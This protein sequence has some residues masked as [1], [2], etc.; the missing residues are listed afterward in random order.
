ML[1]FIL[2]FLLK[3]DESMW[4]KPKLRNGALFMVR[5]A[6]HDGHPELVEGK[7]QRRKILMRNLG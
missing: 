7:K 1:G 6:H 2:N 5:Q 3:P 4:F